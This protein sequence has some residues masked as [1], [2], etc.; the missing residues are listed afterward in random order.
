MGTGR[1]VT[2]RAQD[3]DEELALAFQGGDAAAADELVRRYTG[4]A[5]TLAWPYATRRSDTDDMRQEALCGILA[6]ARTFRVDGGAV[7]K[8]LAIIAIRRRLFTVIKTDN[9]MGRRA[10]EQPLSI[11]ATIDLDGTDEATLEGVIADPFAVDPADALIRREQLQALTHAIRDG[12]SSLERESLIGFVFLDETYIETEQR[13]L[14]GGSGRPRYE[15]AKVVDNALTRARAKLRVA[16]E[17]PRPL[18][19]VA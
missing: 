11:N 13:I 17:E 7:F 1:A 18:G 5:H 2:S 12:L 10:L 3:T 14:P 9:T 19:V 8:S 6:A 15:K 4:I 16:L